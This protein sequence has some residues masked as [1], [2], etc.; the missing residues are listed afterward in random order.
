MTTNDDAIVDAP[1]WRRM[2]RR[3]VLGLAPL[4]LLAAV[5]VPETREAILRG[6]LAA[7]DRGR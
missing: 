1:T 7:T 5:V 2:T 4:S 3:E 6:G